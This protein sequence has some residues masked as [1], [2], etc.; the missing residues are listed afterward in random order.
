MSQQERVNALLALLGGHSDEEFLTHAAL[1]LTTTEIGSTNKVYAVEDDHGAKVAVFKPRDGLS[2]NTAKVYDQTRNSALIAEAV[3]WQ[4]AKALGPPFCDVVA[5]CVL[6]QLGGRVGA[7]TIWRA[8]AAPDALAYTDGR[9]QAL[10]AGLFDAII[11][12][13]DRND[14]NYLWDPSRDELALIDHGYSFAR[15]NDRQGNSV[16]CLW[17]HHQGAAGLTPE[18]V[19]ALRAFA[20]ASGQLGRIEACLEPARAQAL[21]LRVEDMRD[22][23]RLLQPMDFDP[24]QTIA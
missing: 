1:T 20:A 2:L 22:T 21:C 12:Q 5:P 7:L 9:D 17:R 18:E 15:H 8:G 4:V 19:D 16:F 10:T 11:G 14:S 13:Q 3:A 23:Q 6:R 24:T